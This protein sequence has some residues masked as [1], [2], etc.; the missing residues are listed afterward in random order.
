MTIT[1]F[2][3]IDAF[4]VSR[5]EHRFFANWTLFEPFCFCCSIFIDFNLNIFNIHSF[6]INV[7]EIGGYVTCVNFL[8]TRIPLGLT[9]I[10][11]L[12]RISNFLFYV[13]WVQFSY[14]FCKQTK[15][16]FISIFL[17]CLPN[18]KSSSK[19]RSTIRRTSSCEGV[20]LEKIIQ[21]SDILVEEKLGVFY[22]N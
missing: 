19:S 7:S 1:L 3:F 9:K 15:T 8:L 14:Q 21:K 6:L 22:E 18:T 4:S 11:K 10:Y 2:W 12:M 13:F 5:I 17:S 16:H 20:N